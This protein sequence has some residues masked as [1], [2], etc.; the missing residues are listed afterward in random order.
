MKRIKI[1][2]EEKEIIRKALNLHSMDLEMAVHF[3][4]Y[5]ENKKNEIKE[6]YKKVES[7]L[8]KLI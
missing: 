7:L 6:M 1:T 4:N 8:N 3:S 5:E 2:K